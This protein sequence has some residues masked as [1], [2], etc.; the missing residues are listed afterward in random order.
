MAK[1]FLLV[2]GHSL[3]YRAYWA[4]QRGQEGGLRTRDGV[5][6]SITFGFLKALFEVLAKE[7]FAGCAVA[8]DHFLPTFRHEK[9]DTYKA[10]RP[11]TPVEFIQ[12]MDNLKQILTVMNLPTLESIGFEAD[13]ILGTL[14]C[15]G[16][17]AGFT[18]KILSGDQD[19]FQ[20]VNDYIKVLQPNR[21]GGISEFGAQEIYDKLGVWP[22]QVIDY[23]ALRGDSSDNIPGVKGIGEKTAIQ[24]LQTYPDLK[25]IYEHLDDIKGSVQKKL[26]EGTASAQHSYWMATIRTDVPLASDIAACNWQG[27]DLQKVKPLLEALEFKNLIRQVE[28]FGQHTAPVIESEDLWFDF[29]PLTPSS[30]Q[31]TI[32]DTTEGFETFL[33]RLLT[34]TGSVAWDTETT[35]LDPHQAALVGL[36]CAWEVQEAFY[37]PL[38]HLEGNNLDLA[39]VID[40]LQAYFTDPSRP[41]I[42]QNTK[43][44]RLI[45]RKQG[46]ELAGVVF[47]PMLASYV[48][49]PDGDHGLSA[50]TRTLLEVETTSYEQLVPKG[51]TIAEIAI[52]KVA[53]YCAMDALCAYRVSEKLQLKLAEIPQL[54]HV[55]YQLELPLEPVL[56]DMEWLGIR[57]DSDYLHQFSAELQQQLTQLEQ[58]VYIEAGTT[59]NLNSPKQL[60]EVLFDQLQLSTR[61]TRKTSLGWSTDVNVLDKLQ[62]DHPVIDSILEYRTL[63]KLRS[64]YVEALPQ[65]VNP[66]TGRIHTDFNQAVT[67]TGRLSSSNPNLQ[68]IPARTEFSRRIRT[69]FIP[70]EGNYLVAADYSQIELR[71]LAHVSEEPILIETFNQ[72][73]DIHTR[74]AQLLFKRDRVTAD[75]R[76]LAKTIN[77]GVVYG[78]GAQRFAREAG[79]G[80]VEA[81]QF[82]ESFYTTYP[83]VFAYLRETEKSAQEQGYVATLSGRRRYFPHLKE[84]PT[85]QKLAALRQAMNAPIQGTAADIIKQAMITLQQELVAYKTRMLLQVHDELVFEVPQ[86]EWSVMEALIRNTMEQVFPMRVPLKVEIHAGSTWLEAK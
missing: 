29:K 48:L 71:I 35:G 62:G 19:L 59:F 55:F 24:L 20:L 10:G 56:A 41:K 23:K 45:L 72:N 32:V 30:H 26:L 68:N 40:G 22:K 47:D 69:A 5:P 17:K 42:F 70:A 37:L 7:E 84:L 9:D 12:D 85:N 52:P 63:S 11:A 57:I 13:D 39:L 21:L 16:A 61:K 79:M 18:V 8:F 4:F 38:G 34:Q 15:E 83:R 86:A 67:V 46:I 28:R 77:F 53:D 80:S 64:T 50:L 49:Q 51:K 78:M 25:T 44:D 76:R 82:L 75:E 3:A 60:S 27:F 81:Q 73:G 66:I 65:L 14:A 36:G 58:K 2:D 43:F 74:T 33:T 31:V 1:T 54:A 6:T